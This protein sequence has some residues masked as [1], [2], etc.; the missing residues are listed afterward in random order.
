MVP[1]ADSSPPSSMTTADESLQQ[2][3][4]SAMESL[5]RPKTK[6]HL[7]A[8]N[9]HTMYETFKLAQERCRLDILGIS[10]CRLT[11]SGRQTINDGSVI[12]HSR[13]EDR[14][15]HGV[16]LIVS[17][18]KAKT[19]LEWEPVNDRI[20]RAGFNSRHCKP[21]I[22]Q[23]YAPTNE[24]EKEEKDDSYEELQRTVSKVPLHD[25]LLIIG[26]V[27]ARVG[28]DY[29]NCDRPIGSH[30]CGVRNGNGESLVDFCLKNSCI[31]GEPP[32]PP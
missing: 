14:H 3:V 15:I 18:A 1:T 9:V 27:N 12:L 32:R 16:A 7:G 10:E 23:C 6:I 11:G 8:W 22:I 25:M 20:I 26:N 13:Y 17:K 21:T 24:A 29:N 2:E 28:A 4:R 31:V 19:L 30:G 5:L